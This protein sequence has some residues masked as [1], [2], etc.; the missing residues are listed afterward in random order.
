MFRSI[1]VISTIA[2][3]LGLLGCTSAEQ[4]SD[5]AAST[6]EIQTAHLTKAP[7]GSASGL[8]NPGTDLIDLYTYFHMNPELSFKEIN[9]SAIM[10]NELESLG[11]AVTTGL[12]D[13]WTRAKSMR[14]YG[15]VREGVGGYGVVGVFENGDGPTVLIRADMDALPVAE[16]TGVAHAS[17]IV[18]ET[19]T[20]VSNGVMHACGHDIHMTSWVGTARDLIAAKDQWSG[21]LIMIAQPAEELGNGAKA[22]IADGLFE[23]FPQPDYNLALHVSAGA[24]SGQVAYSSGFA[25]AN[26]DS[27]DITVKGV[28][29]HGAYPHT[30]KDP[31]LVGASIVTA[32][33]SLVSRNVNP[34][35]P[36]VVT[37]GSFQAGA[38]HNIISDE[39][40]LLLTVRSYDD[41][42]RAML[43]EGIERIAKA[44]AMAFGAPEP[45]IFIEPDYTPSTYNDPELAATAADAIGRVIGSE[46]IN[47][48]DPVMGGED[49]SQYGRTDAKIPSLIFW[50]GAV[51]PE[52]WDAA[53]GGE[54]ALPSLHSPFFAPDYEPT[55]ETG[56]KSMTATALALFREG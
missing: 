18:D 43:L 34:Q 11:F 47:R 52:K 22:M 55:I 38:K 4:A 32:V 9:S 45:E 40:K 27:V 26:V 39:A 14:D 7:A 17:Q 3:S 5:A 46:N 36:A 51:H 35:T 16:R 13:A 12:G 41:A 20:G 6:S 23:R 30:T 29:G 21:T 44:Q 2:I 37:V 42:T 53:Q 8:P 49:F 33:Q 28:G 50:V 56:V 48:V 19:W 25:L 31:V 1:S 10:A 54:L 15:T 24:P